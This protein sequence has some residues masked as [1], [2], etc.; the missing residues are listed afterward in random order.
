MMRGYGGERWV[1]PYDYKR[2]SRSLG[3]DGGLDVRSSAVAAADEEAGDEETVEL[4][5]RGLS[6]AGRGLT[7]DG[8]VS[9][10][11]GKNYSTSEIEGRRFDPRNPPAD[12][13]VEEEFELLLQ[14]KKYFWG[15]ARKNL[16]NFSRE[17]KW[18]LICSFRAK[19]SSNCSNDSLTAP[20]LRNQL[21]QDLDRSLRA[22]GNRSKNLHQ[23]E[24]ALR[25]SSFAQ[26]FLAQDGIKTLF[27]CSSAIETDDQYV[28]LRCFKTLMN[29]DQARFEILNFPALISYFCGL[30][31]DEITRLSCKL[32]SAEILLLLTYV[33]QKQ[34]Y[35]KVLKGLHGQIKEWFE[36][37]Q[38]ILTAE[39]PDHNEPFYARIKAE[40][41]RNN[42][43]LTSMFL[44]NS[45]GQALRVKGQK[46]KFIRS[47]KE[48]K[49]HH[50]F[51]LMKQLETSDIDKQIEMYVELERKILESCF[52][53]GQ[54]ED[55][56]YEPA[57]Q[58]LINITKGTPIEQDLSCLIDSF[59]QIV[60]S[61]TTAESIKIFKSL[62]S[63]LDYLI[64]NFC[65]NVPSQPATLVQE[66]INKFLDK[67]ESD[68]VARRAMNEMTELENT[69]IS[70]RKQL[71]ELKEL[72][73]TSKEKLAKE[74]KYA[75]TINETKDTEIL[76]LSKKLEETK[77]LRKK[78][79][80][81]LEHARRSSDSIKGNSHSVFENLKTRAQLNKTKPKRVRSMLKSQRL[82]SLSSYIKTSAEA[83]SIDNPYN[84]GKPPDESGKVS[85]SSFSTSFEDSF[86]HS[87]AVGTARKVS[88]GSEGESP[89]QL[90]KKRVR[91]GK[92]VDE[93][94]M[95]RRPQVGAAPENI[96]IAS[97]TI[98]SIENNKLA[99]SAQVPSPL[100]SS[101]VPPPP[102]PPPLPEAFG[103]ASREQA[104]LCH[105]TIS[106]GNIPPPPPLPAGF[107]QSNLSKPQTK[108][109]MKQIHW[110]K[111][112]EIS[113]TLWE[114]Q[115]QK[116][117]TFKELEKGGIFSQIE[118]CFK[119]KERAVKP[120]EKVDIAEK[121]N[122]KTFLPRDLAQQFGINLHMF[123]QYSPDE[124]VLKVLK[125]D[126]EILQNSTALE[127]FTREDLVKIPSSLHKLFGPYSSDYLH[128]HKPEKDPSELDRPDRI[129]LDLCYNLRTYWYERSICLLTLTTYERDYYDLVYR[130][131][132]I[133]DVIQRLKHGVRFKNFL[134][135]VVEI[136]NYMNK[137]PAQGI[138]LSS[139]NKLAFVKSSSNKSVSFLHFIERLI[140]M[141]YPD[142]YGFTEE[143][144]KV[145]DLGKISLDHL[146]QECSDFRT[147]ID[148]VVS[149]IK[150]G[151]LSDP[152]TLHPEDLVV[153]KLTY[154]ANR[155]QKK[156]DLLQD[157]LKLITNDLSKLMR[158][159]G[160]D[161][162]KPEAKDIFF[163]NLIEFSQTFKKCA[164]ENAEREECER[165][166]EQR[167]IMIE[168]RQRSISNNNAKSQD[169]ED[170]VDILL[171]KLRGV[172]KNSALVRRR[173]STKYFDI[174][175]QGKDTSQ[176]P[177]PIPAGTNA[178][179]LE[180]T[181][182]MLE[183]IHNI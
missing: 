48:N 58:Q 54:L 165:V 123:S 166:Y 78:D 177:R 127:F 70:L 149:I 85:D 147:K 182:A 98:S 162:E 174:S 60:G 111:L 2:R 148:T 105:E 64:D 146:E 23:L 160:E 73:D 31:V 144:S 75:K 107:L 74:L 118:S 86:L 29:Y 18:S 11:L 94:V 47:L 35:Q 122:T 6:L 83:E 41:N 167:K 136:G 152:S 138:R 157:Q 161:Y 21:L 91:L 25:Q 139:L 178:V 9:R 121:S 65:T 55:S 137:R 155:A 53:K 117:Q 159:Y 5:N 89:N 164:K 30:V 27:H 15:E 66:S 33:D 134:Y 38:R 4:I 104:G 156:A 158:Y 40:K 100:P 103:K 97:S 169:E 120:F 113:E 84:K 8:S 7:G 28:Y 46:V 116:D 49:I 87:D 131:Q 32:A 62:R 39:S 140:R 14:D 12:G 92:P 34:G 135:I 109:F 179:L 168:T 56:V 114:D 133:D 90:S 171:A 52:P 132:K 20:L 1:D 79:E 50:C 10:L 68:E 76:E 112:D 42:F 176:K 141:K 80:I 181:H 142:L 110:E 71:N 180:R 170:A 108:E 36:C 173:R 126:A 19:E 150:E 115:E 143:L 61:R 154:K 106:S 81:K 95:S 45:I 99:A 96:D 16:P 67:L 69:I 172:E 59:N 51:H 37:L 119:I 72:K 183:D 26:A 101:P 102:P 77:E 57:L 125:C 43:V 44:I 129:F 88:P 13:S 153:K 151:K 82:E 24:K 175:S 17:K 3:N 163:Q 145:E 63:I 130:L 128:D 22:P 124:F 93:V